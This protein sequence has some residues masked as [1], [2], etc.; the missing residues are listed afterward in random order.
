MGPVTAA[1]SGLRPVRGVPVGRS[2]FLQREAGQAP[3]L[4]S[5]PGLGAV[6]VEEAGG[7][8]PLPTGVPVRGQ[9]RGRGRP[10]VCQPG[11]A[12]GPRRPLG[13]CS[14][15][16]GPSRKPQPARGGQ[17]GRDGASGRPWP[18]GLCLG[19]RA[20]AETYEGTKCWA[21]WRGALQEPARD[22]GDQA[23][24]KAPQASVSVGFGV[25][26]LRKLPL[27]LAGL[28]WFLSLLPKNALSATLL[29]L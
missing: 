16:R 15:R 27:A 10:R 26:R 9:R 22:G 28:S 3:P 25:Q 11:L 23:G 1:R 18:A 21:P 17:Q 19:A 12:G 24:D 6:G 4:G 20:V 8:R 7:P 13:V 29:H 14:V 5:S 2:R